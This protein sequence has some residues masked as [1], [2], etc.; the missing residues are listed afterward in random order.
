M[1][2]ASR[3]SLDEA[4][5]ALTARSQ[6]D[7]TAGY[8]ELATELFSV[9]RL[10]DDNLDLRRV[11]S[12][13]GTDV[14]RRESLV[15]QLLTGKVQESTV[16]AVEDV[17]RRRWSEASD[18]ADV[19]EAMG[20][21]ALFLAAEDDGSLDTVEDEL[22]RLSRIVENSVELRTA[23][24]DRGLPTERKVDLVRDLLGG[25]VAPAT[26]TIS[27][28]VVASPRGRRL[29]DALGELAR[30]ASDRH[31]EVMAEVHVA[32][33]MGGDQPAR[34]AAA[35]TRIY[36]RPVRIAQVVEPDLIGGV[37]V[38]VGDEVIDGTVARRLEQARQQL[39]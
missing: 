14:G 38:V 10:L 32:A 2:G 30:L 34:L 6:A 18:L 11:L 29:E 33:P 31:G 4:R 39:A 13:S 1:L 23:L 7:G 20:A 36:G 25:R 12:D 16:A 21:H 37:K 3:R 22:Y 28:Q 5:E 24:S 27:E 19:V 26:L 8:P 9:A 17:V 15:R 35:L